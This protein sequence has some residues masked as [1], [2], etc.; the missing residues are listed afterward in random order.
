[1]GQDACAAEA[2]EFMGRPSAL[3]RVPPGPCAPRR[4][5]SLEA[6]WPLPSADAPARRSCDHNHAR[7]PGLQQ[8][9]ASS[10]GQAQPGRPGRL[11]PAPAPATQ[12]PQPKAFGIQVLSKVRSVMPL[13]LAAC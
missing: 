1:M 8:D 5:T 4:A 7:Q 3:V 13:S 10:R 11:Q 6:A 2:L 9:S 12:S